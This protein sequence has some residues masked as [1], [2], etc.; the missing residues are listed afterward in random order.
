MFQEQEQEQDESQDPGETPEN[1]EEGAAEG[2]QDDGTFI[3]QIEDGTGIKIHVDTQKLEERWEEYREIFFGPELTEEEKEQLKKLKDDDKE[4][5]IH[6][7]FIVRKKTAEERAQDKEEEEEEEEA[8]ADEDISLEEVDE[9][10]EERRKNLEPKCPS[11]E[12]EPASGS[13]GIPYIS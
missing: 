5:Y 10:K 7:K 2:G 9:R 1:E 6:L 13:E 11:A 4:F 8:E 12:S 3:K